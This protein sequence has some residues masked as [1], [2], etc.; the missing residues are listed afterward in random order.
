[1]LLFPI[2]WMFVTAVLPSE[3]V[4]TMTPGI[5]PSP[6]DMSMEAFV[7]VVERKP[8]IAWFVN[9][10]VVTIGSVMLSVVISAL[11]GYSLSRFNLG[12]EQIMG[13]AL[14]VSRMLPGT[15]LVIPLYIMFSR[16]GMINSY[17]ALVLANIVSI[18]PFS[19]WM[20]KGFYDGI[21]A[22]LEEA[23]S[24]DGCSWFMS[25]RRVVLP[26]TLPGLERICLRPH[27]GHGPGEMDVYRRPGILRRRAFGRLV[28]P[29]GGRHHFHSADNHIL[30]FSRAL[31]GERPD[32]GIGQGMTEVRS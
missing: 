12:G 1:V 21:P 16:L 18:V 3:K 19:T 10:G 5:L 15:M 32:P 31:P 20:M 7:R 26:L 8:V 6:A 29:D 4:L 25:F 11:A 27:P 13:Y 22:E 17:A 28:E 24:I 23:A 9:S 14:L 30:L 2:Y